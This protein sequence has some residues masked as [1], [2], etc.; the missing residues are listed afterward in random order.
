MNVKRIVFVL[1]LCLT[2]VVG[3][4]SAINYEEARQQ[5][6]FLTDKMAY[7]LNLT[8]E[9]YDRAYQINLDYLM[10][11]NSQ[12]DCY[13]YYWNYRD[14]DLRC[15]LFDWQYTLY[16]SIDYFFRPIRLLNRSWYYPIY[17]RY[18]TGYYYFNRPGVYVSYR[19]GLWQRRSHNSPSPYRG[20]TPNGG[21]GLRDRYQSNRG[22]S[23]YRPELGRPG[24]NV[25]SNRP[26]TG[27]ARPNQG[28]NNSRP[29]GNNSGAV[30][31]NSRPIANTSG[32]ATNTSRPNTGRNTGTTRPST[33]NTGGNNRSNTNST[34]GNN[35]KTGGRS[36]GTK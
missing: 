7:E 18:R 2:T 19:G 34:G 8:A 29:G 6:W 22:G 30:P 17:G 26:G 35:N 9:Q 1:L 11:I 20:F 4:L 16:A 10:S 14:S 24:T 31:N 21:R 33:G 27:N 3:K 25:G 36:F 32:P 23:N 12:S 13:G 28:N 15:I 5:A